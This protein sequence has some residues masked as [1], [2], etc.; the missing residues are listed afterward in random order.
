MNRRAF[1]NT[2]FFAPLVIILYLYAWIYIFG[3]VMAEY[4]TNLAI[5]QG[6]TGLEGLLWRTMNVWAG[7]LPLLVYIIY[8]GTYGGGE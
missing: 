2:Y 1:F 8:V 4:G 7:L 3:P 6:M 5:S